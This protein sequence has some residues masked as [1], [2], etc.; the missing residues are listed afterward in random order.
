MS[1]TGIK[2]PEACGMGRGSECCIYMG[3]GPDGMECLRGTSLEG[4]LNERH[5]K[6]TMSAGRK[7]TEPRPECQSVHEPRASAAAKGGEDAAG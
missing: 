4:I 3:A 7:P 5:A 1:D 2:N 6:G